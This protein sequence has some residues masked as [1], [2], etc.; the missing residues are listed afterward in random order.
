MGKWGSYS[1]RGEAESCTHIVSSK[2]TTRMHEHAHRG[3]LPDSADAEMPRTI[4]TAY[5]QRGPCYDG[6]DS[7]NIDSQRITSS[8]VMRKVE[9]R[10]ILGTH[11]R[12]LFSRFQIPQ[13]LRPRETDDRGTDVRETAGMPRGPVKVEGNRQFMDTHSVVSVVGHQF[14]T[15]QVHH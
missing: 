1:Q 14:L 4:H 6:R 9:A 13:R 7:S 11:S 8:L 15:G 5:I 3:I 2:S 10:D 12:R